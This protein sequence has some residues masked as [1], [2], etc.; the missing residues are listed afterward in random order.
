MKNV[1]LVGGGKIGVAITQFLSDSGDYR[2]TV[3]DRDAEELGE[4]L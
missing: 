3:A 1:L 4:A 2:I